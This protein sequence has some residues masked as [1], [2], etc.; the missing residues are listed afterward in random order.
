[1]NHQ[2]WRL[3]DQQLTLFCHIQPGARQSQLA[4]LYDNCIKIQL[5]APPVDG[6][7]NKALIDYLAQLLA[8]P[9]TSICITRGHNNRRKTITI[10]G[11]SQLP[12]ALSDL[13][14]K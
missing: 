2:P 8:R 4:G 10:D 13:A 3:S 7:A 5:A 9:R 6:K 1:M 14:Q 12:C 11:I